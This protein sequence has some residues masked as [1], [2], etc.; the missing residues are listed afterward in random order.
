MDNKDK[1]IYLYKAKIVRIVDGD[2]FDAEVD[3]GFHTTIKTRFRLADIDTPELRIKE[4]HE[5]AVKAK[6][7]LEEKLLVG[8]TYYLVSHKSD[9]FGRWLATVYL[10]DG[11]TINGLMLK[12]GLAKVYGE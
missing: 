4:Q 11:S 12:E 5:A 3:L 10:D 6:R 9:K 1:Q 2:T 8:G 7:F